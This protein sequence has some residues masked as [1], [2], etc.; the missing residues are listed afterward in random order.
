MEASIRELMAASATRLL[1]SMMIVADS[2]A[3]F[4]AVEQSH[5]KLP[6]AQPPVLHG[7]RALVE[8]IAVDG[9][10]PHAMR[11][12][13][14]LGSIMVS[15]AGT[16]VQVAQVMSWVDAG[17]TGTFCMTDRGGP[18]ASQ[19]RSCATTGSP[20]KLTVDKVWAMNASRA[21]FALIVVRRGNSMILAPVLLAPDVYAQAATQPSG[22]AF[23]DGHL[24]L[25][26]VQAM[27]E[28]EPSWFLN[29]GGPISP[30]I[31]LTLARPWLV[32]ALCSHLAW[33]ARHNRI[34]LNAEMGERVAFLRQAAQNQANLGVFDRFSEDQAMAL[35]WIA[36]EIFAEL[37]VSGAVR[38]KGDQRD[39]LGFSKMEGSSY[40]CFFEIY[41][42]NKK[43]RRVD[44]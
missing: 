36:N 9:F 15:L 6:V 21:D 42:R 24:P 19:W 32:Q 25:A 16:A 12:F 23:L 38:H 17:L 13:G 26:N 40:R 22:A 27:L 44:G 29:E 5:V 41:E 2:C 11:F 14:M 4:V 3:P 37:V 33:L 28:A 10:G 43:L 39:L 1:D 34:V 31:F 18:L 8:E 35:K 20:V 7:V 30:K